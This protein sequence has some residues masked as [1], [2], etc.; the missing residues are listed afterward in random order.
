MQALLRL[1]DVHNI[2][3]ATNVATAE[4]SNRVLPAEIWLGATSSIRNKNFNSA[5][6]YCWLLMLP[7]LLCGFILPNIMITIRGIKSGARF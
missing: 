7:A 5:Q 3:V 4:C 6:K 1:C 2:P